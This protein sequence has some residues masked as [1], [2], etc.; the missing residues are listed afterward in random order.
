[1]GLCN[2][3]SAGGASLP[4]GGT[5]RD[6]SL[7]ILFELLPALPELDAGGEALEL[8]AGGGEAGAGE[9]VPVPLGALRA[10]AGGGTVLAT[11]PARR[12]SALYCALLRSATRLLTSFSRSTPLSCVSGAAG[13]LARFGKGS[14]LPSWRFCSFSPLPRLSFFDRPVASRYHSIGLTASGT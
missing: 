2:E 6:A 14:L 9:I 11:S 4:R 1:V 12:L 13:T 10:G 8:A 7:A 3:D 5:E